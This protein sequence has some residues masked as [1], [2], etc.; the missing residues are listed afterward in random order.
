MVLLLFRGD[1]ILQ[2]LGGKGFDDFLGRD[3]D[4]GAG[5]GIPSHAR[6]AGPDLNVDQSII[7]DIS[8]AE[9]EGAITGGSEVVED[10]PDDKC[11]PSFLI[12]GFTKAGRALHMQCSYPS[13][14]LIKI[15]TLYEPDPDLWVGFRIRK[16][17][18]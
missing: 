6:L 1:Y 18:Q 13:R 16:Q 12:L 9:M 4:G 14:P 5:L 2:G 11:G 17:D 8:V 10:Y 7:R 15:V 3:L